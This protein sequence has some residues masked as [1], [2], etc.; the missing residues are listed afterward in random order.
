[1][2]A[3]ARKTH[4]MDEMKEITWAYTYVYVFVWYDMIC[5]TFLEEIVLDK[6]GGKRLTL[7]FVV[8]FFQDSF[9][10]HPWIAC[11]SEQD[12]FIKLWTGW[13][14]DISFKRNRQKNLI[15]HD[16]DE[17]IEIGHIN[18]LMASDPMT[19]FPLLNW[20]IGTNT[21]NCKKL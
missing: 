3:H 2:R 18:L 6:E 11:H 9:P 21:N 13:L 17:N 1:M 5:Y 19:S 16:L 10:F 15:I 7:L 12:E 20:N 4:H 8:V 14:C